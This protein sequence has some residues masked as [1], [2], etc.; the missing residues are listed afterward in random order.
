VS[1]LKVKQNKREKQR[2]LKTATKKL[3]SDLVIFHSKELWLEN[4]TEVACFKVKQEG[5]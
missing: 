4:M 2:K 3:K 5:N 1:E